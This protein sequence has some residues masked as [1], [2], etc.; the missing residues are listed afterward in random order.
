MLLK[1]AWRNIFR[2]KRRSFIT[3][4]S[5]VFAVLFAVFMR[6]LQFGAYGHMLHNIVGSYLGYIQ[7]HEKGFWEEKTID[8]SF[9]LEEVEHLTL[10]DDVSYISGRVEGFALASYQEISKPVAILGINN[11]NPMQGVGMENKVIAGNY[12]SSVQEGILIAK[13]LQEIMQLSIGDTLV[14]LGQGY[15]GAIASGA[16]PIIGVLDLK[17]PELNKRTVVMHIGAAQELF[18]LPGLVT[19][20]LVGIPN[21]RWQETYATLNSTVDTASLEVMTWQE[22]LPE[23]EQL[24]SVDQAGGMFV[25][26]IL[27]SI[28]AFSL[29]GTVLMLAEERSF[30]YGVL[31]AIGMEKQ[32]IIVV[33]V[34]ETF[35]MAA[36]GIVAGLIVAF[37]FVLYFNLNPINLSGQMQEAVEKFGFE[38]LIPTSLDPSIALT[39]ASIIFLIVL[40]V[41]IYTFFKIKR[42]QPINAMRR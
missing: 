32:K 10:L 34:L 1:L 38:A 12:F 24:I 30:E 11:T 16:Y 21:D 23:L 37:P 19:S 6:S 33:A 35:I 13:G 5:V 36:A 41:N 2:N 17:T 26:L 14:F 7:I 4:S 28:I 22:M 3:V 29:F 25:L 18:V 15:H 42:L 39:H 20:A 9:A 31:V 27:Y 40:V 8:N